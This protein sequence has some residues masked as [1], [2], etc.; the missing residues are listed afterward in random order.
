L[1]SNT[2]ETSESCVHRKVLHKTKVNIIRVF[3]SFSVLM[4]L[5]FEPTSSHLSHTPAL[6][7]LVIFQVKFPPFSPL[8]WPETVI[9]LPRP[10]KHEAPSQSCS[11]RQGL[12][13]FFAWTVL[14]PQSSNLCLPS[15]WTYR[16]EPP[17]QALTCKFLTL[18]ESGCHVQ[19][20]FSA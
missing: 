9:R 20:L 12:L 4:S 14:K 6:Y 1:L 10:L 16:H 8:Q 3:I 11:L 5:G 7:A 2:R 13:N 15:S 18:V 19:E 17:C